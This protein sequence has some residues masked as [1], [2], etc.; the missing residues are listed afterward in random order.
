V[1]KRQT[2]E[3][4]CRS[5]TAAVAALSSVLYSAPFRGVYRAA[6]AVMLA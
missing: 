2:R 5:H 4:D 6:I 1:Y 3:L